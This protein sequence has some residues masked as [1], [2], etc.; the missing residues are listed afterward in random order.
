MEPF[1]YVINLFYSI[2]GYTFFMATKGHVFDLKPFSSFWRNRA[3]V[4]DITVGI[5]CTM[6]IMCIL[7]TC[8][9]P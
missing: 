8:A 3:R 7:E 2:V 5:M 1:S 9:Q 4:R 6:C